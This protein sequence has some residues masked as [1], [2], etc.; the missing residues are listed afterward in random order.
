M[1]GFG[2]RPAVLI[3]IP[4]EGMPRVWVHGVGLAAGG[5]ERVWDWIGQHPE[6]GELVELALEIAE[7]QAT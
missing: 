5:E 7:A 3:E 1:E 6:L 4:V 2:E